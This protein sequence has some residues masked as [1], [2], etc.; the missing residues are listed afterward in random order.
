[1]EEE[2]E[3]EDEE[4]TS[5]PIRG[6]IPAASGRWASC[7][8]LIGATTG[9]SKC[10]LELGV[11]EAALS[12]CTCRFAE[13][14]QESLVVVG[15]CSDLQLHP[16]RWSS[17]ALL[18]YR[19]VE[20]R[21]LLLHRTEVEDI[22]MCLAEFQGRLLVGVGRSLRMYDMGKRKLLKKCEHRGLQ[23]A[24][25]RLQVSGD[26]IFVGDLMESLTVVKYRR[27]ENTLSVFADDSATRF[28][29]AMCVLDHATVAAAD[30][31]GSVFV[32]R[33]PEDANEDAEA[34]GSL[35]GQ[36]GGVNKLELLSHYYLGEMVT[37]ITKSALKT[38]GREVLLASTVTGG[39]YAFV[40]ARSKEEVTFFSHLEMFM[41]QEYSSLCQR[42]HL[43]YRSYFQPVKR[44]IDAEL[45]ER[46]SS[47]PQGK[48]R[49]FAADMDRSAAEIV[50][51]LEELRDL[52]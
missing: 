4:G 43:S 6:P 40:P 31:F 10:V 11:N 16:K 3:D 18:V 47:L 33:I 30:K 48:Q 24:V 32:L 46:F 17:C 13:H 25:V 42:D 5:M 51:K 52:V 41:R 36:G 28:I 44:T 2:A 26:H 15:T 34:Q 7:V 14:A 23:A 50:K 19:V 39:L 38:Q 20:G 49:E 1:L 8:R 21:L 12:V 9:E 45:C 29:T 27:N 35:W 37:S 22:P